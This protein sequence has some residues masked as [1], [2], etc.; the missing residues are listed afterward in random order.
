MQNR[1]WVFGHK[2]GLT[3]TPA[4]TAFSVAQF[5]TYEGCAAISDLTGILALFSDGV[6]VWDG[7]GALRA[8]GLHGSGSS[9]QSAVIVPDPGSSKRFYVL[10]TAGASGG[11]HHFDG[12]RIDTLTWTVAPIVVTP[13][14]PTAGYSPTEK[15]TAIRHGNNHDYWVLTVVQPQTPFPEDIGPGLLRIFLVT[16]TGISHVFDKLLP[17]PVSDIGYIRASK[18][19]EHIAIASMFCNNVQIVSFSAL[20]GAPSMTGAITIPVT[21]PPFNTGGYVYGVEFSPGGKLLYYSTLFPLPTWSSPESDG[22]VFQYQLP[23][24]PPVLVGTH[25]NNVG[26]DCALGTLQLADDGKIYIAQDGEN[27]LGVIAHPDVPGTG[28]GLTFN[29]LT[30]AAGT[31]CKAGLPNLIRDLTII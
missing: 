25:P 15:L 6:S 30:L 16:S 4:P 7:T 8:T 21:V 28:C 10:T 17:H 27:K 23:N 1:N 20:T 13:P 19:G 14:P 9:S 11:N 22:H 31:N 29:A 5:D 2:A 24:G 12:I 18:G 3:F 26:P